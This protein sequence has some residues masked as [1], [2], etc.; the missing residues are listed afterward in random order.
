MGMLTKT[1]RSQE[2]R[3][4]PALDGSPALG[5]AAVRIMADGTS[6]PAVADFTSAPRDWRTTLPALGVA[7][8][9]F[10]VAFAEEGRAAVAVWNAST[11]YNH[12]WLVLPVAA[13]L[14]WQ[15]RDRLAELSPRPFPAAAAL[16]LPAG[17]AWLAAERLGIMEGRQLAAMGMLWTLILTVLGWRIC[18]AMAGPLLYL[19]FLVP[20]GAFATPVLQDATAWMIEMGLRLLDI[21]YHRDGLLIETT[22]G[23]FHVAEACAG[24]RFLIAANAFGAL[25]AL[26][27]FRSPGRRL[28]VMLL[29]VAVPV[30]ANGL[31]A[32][33]IVVL[34]AHLGSAEA[35]A[36]DHVIYGWG[37]FSAIILLLILVGLLFREDELALTPIAPLPLGP[38][39][40]LAPAWVAAGVALALAAIGP[41]TA[42]ALTIAGGSAPQDEPARLTAPPGC[43]PAE[44]GPTL[45]CAGAHVTA[46]MLVFSPRVTW[47]AV[48]AELW[49]VAGGDTDVTYAVAVPDG[50]GLWR[51]RLTDERGSAVAVAAWLDGAPAGDGLRSRVAQALNSLG[52]GSSAPVVAIVETRP[53]G[54]GGPMPDADLLRRVLAA[55]RQ[56]G[57]AGLAAELSR[58]ATRR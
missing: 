44:G 34:A 28:A 22:A 1:D 20:F 8:L 14:G 9:L 47:R 52:R 58:G 39:P 7:L 56:D 26:V 3:P 13:W 32:L 18:R 50:Q 55:Q 17:L 54:G 51:A 12:C 36:A 27:M 21:S 2:P 37:F 46:R 49:S 4:Q 23:L 53:D 24:L 16:M 6:L 19:V 15:R 11:A 30:V 48:S 25:Y 42:A 35:A 43:E 38:A 5:S 41:A 57:I 29:A 10:A 33:G 40:R 45:R 31:R